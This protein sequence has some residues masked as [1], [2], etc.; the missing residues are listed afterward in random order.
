MYKL[1]EEDIVR[2]TRTKN[3][4]RIVTIISNHVKK[5]IKNYLIVS[6]IF[7]IGISL[8]VI[9]IN[10][11]QS[12]AKEEISNYLNNFITSIN[13]EYQ[14]DKMQLLTN[15]IWKNVIF[16]ITM[17]FAGSTVIGI[18]IVLGLVAYRGFC[19]GYTVSASIYTF[20]AQN[21]T[22]FFLSSIFLQNIL[23]IPCILALAVSGLKLYK[24]II[25]D[26]R[27]ENV[28]IEIVRHTIFSLI[29]LILLILSSLIETYISASLLQMIANIIIK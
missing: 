11:M 26:R 29:M 16:C 24:S 17:W 14:I 21:G 25:K 15:S 28:K 18:P 7:F 23:I 13:G 20:G 6:I 10:N 1:H 5:N 2:N 9:F 22:L 12:E 19:I 8:A 27:R 3:K 4:S